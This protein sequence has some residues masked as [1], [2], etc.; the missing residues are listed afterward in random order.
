M[1]NTTKTADG[2]QNGERNQP[3]H[4]AKVRHGYGKKAT[5]ERVGVA[6]LNEEKGSIYVK[7]YGTQVLSALTLYER[8]GD[9]T[10]VNGEPGNEPA[11]GEELAEEA[12]G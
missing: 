4:I 7:L 2:R 6:W 11:H 12:V 9:D 3:T 1:K 10:A 8:G 5:Y